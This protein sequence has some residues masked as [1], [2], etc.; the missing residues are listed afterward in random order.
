MGKISHDQLLVKSM[1]IG[2]TLHNYTSTLVP[3]S[4]KLEEVLIRFE[5]LFTFTKSSKKVHNEKKKIER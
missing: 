5:N 3:G 4:I 1:D 2:Y